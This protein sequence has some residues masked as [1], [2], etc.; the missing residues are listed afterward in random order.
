MKIIANKLGKKFKKKWLFKNFSYEFLKN[1]IY[2]II[3]KNGSGK[4][5]LMKII[6]GYTTPSIGKI[7]YFKNKE[8]IKS[9]LLFQYNAFTAPYIE[10]IEE[11]TLREFLKFHFNFNNNKKNKSINNIIKFISLE[12]NAEN[13]IKDFSSG[14]KQKLKL[15]I[16]FLSN[17]PIILLD[18][19]YS[20]LDEENIKWYL[21]NL[22]KII[23]KKIIII[24]SNNK[25]EYKK[26]KILINLEKYN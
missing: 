12:D 25:N 20:N 3:G 15:G 4:S 17:S 5:T 8:K 11:L 13:Y 16:I 1:N 14:M 18:E 6:S 9:N 23:N 19:P 24:F 21:N 26:C 7:E 10:L 22:N 2:A